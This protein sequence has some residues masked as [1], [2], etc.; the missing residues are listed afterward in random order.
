MLKSIRIGTKL[1]IGFGISLGLMVVLGI[2]S[3]I[4]LFSVDT[5]VNQYRSVATAAHTVGELQANFLQA[6]LD[7]KNFMIDGNPAHTE[8]A[9]RHFALARAANQASRDATDDPEVLALLADLDRQ[10]DAYEA[11][12]L[13]VTVLDT[14]REDLVTLMRAVGPAIEAALAAVMKE[15]DAAGDIQA[16]YRAGVVLQHLLQARIHASRFVATGNPDQSARALQ[17]LESIDAAVPALLAA[18]DDPQMRAR[19]EAAVGQDEQYHEAFVELIDVITARDGLMRD[20]LD[21]IGPTIVSAI[22]GF[23]ETAKEAR[24]TLG[25]QA[26]ALI[27]QTILVTIVIAAVAVILGVLAA[28]VIGAGITHPIRA[29]TDAMRRLA[30]RDYGVTIPAQ[31]H[32]DEIGD[33]AKTVQVFKDSMETADRLAAEQAEEVRQREARAE[34]IAALNTR[35][36]E[37]VHGVLKAVAEATTQ[38]QG[39]SESMAAIAEQTTSQATT[40]ASASEEASSNVQTVASAAEELAASIHEIGRQVQQT[41]DI[42]NN[43]AAEADRTTGVV[44]GL[45]EASQKI[46][47][48]V[49]LITDIA[50]Q[51]NLLALNATIEAARA[52]DAGKGFAVV[53]NE[54]KSL[55][56]QTARATEDIGRQIGAVQTET[57]TAV[58]AIRSIAEIIGTI[59]E[60]TTAIA[61]AVEEQNAAT[62]EISRNVQ[63]ASHGTSEVSHTITGVSQ[64]AQEAGVAAS[65]VLEA[66]GT[67]RSQSTTLRTMVEE[68]LADVRAA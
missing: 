16:T 10:I 45:A 67:L 50:D 4:Q 42:A 17:D 56:N 3:T 20:T 13:E 37:R 55:A 52:G 34:R 44:S 24:D 26:V 51:T 40:V 14:R 25:P 15:A 41:N 62:A 63:Q 48:V 59:N 64:A 33:M 47:E 66:T 6:R 23:N 7:V 49:N 1:Y 12:F 19:V 53:A 54:V 29:M 5:R 31:D 60:A 9:S 30:D 2:A 8:S 58:E 35:F 32:G 28:W 46:G 65:S 36:D 22:E 27:G 39:A 18:L 38:L 61:S 57:R 21:V 43:A 11:A 68:F